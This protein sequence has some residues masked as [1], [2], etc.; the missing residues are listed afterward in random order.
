MS[1]LTL[2]A[3]VL[4]NPTKLHAG[5]HCLRSKSTQSLQVYC[6][7][8]LQEPSNKPKAIKTRLLSWKGFLMLESLM[9]SKPMSTLR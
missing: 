6:R 8:H 9:Q 2:R 7:L 3:K 5:S 4:L 1:M